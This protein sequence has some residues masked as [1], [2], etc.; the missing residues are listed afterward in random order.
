MYQFNNNFN[1]QEFQGKFSPLGKLKS[2]P[3]K[4]D[5][6]ADVEEDEGDWQ[7]PQFLKSSGPSQ[8]ESSGTT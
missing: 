2:A 1:E 4:T 5:I 6:N 3:H 7:V 8:A